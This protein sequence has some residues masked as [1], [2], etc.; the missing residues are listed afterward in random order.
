MINILSANDYIGS[1]LTVECIEDLTHPDKKGQVTY[2]G[3]LK[4]IILESITIARLN[5]YR[6]LNEEQIKAISEKNIH[7]HFMEASS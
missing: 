3:N 2:S 6:Y 4:S 5:A 1:V 7:Y